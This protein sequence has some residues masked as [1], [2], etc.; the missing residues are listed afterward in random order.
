MKK[1]NLLLFLL[2]SIGLLFQCKPKRKE[3][4]ATVKEA[5]AA[6]AELPVLPDSIAN[7]AIR[8][9]P[10]K[11][12]GNLIV[13]EDGKPVQLQGM[14][15][16]WSQWIG[17]YYNAKAIRWLKHDWNC[18][19]VRAAMAVEYDGYLTQPGL[20]QKKVFTVIDAAVKEGLYVIV[21]WHDHHGEDH[22]IEAK[23]FFA[24]VA[25]RYGHLPNVIYETY[26]EPMY[27]S[28]KEILKPYHQAII[29]TIRYYDPDNLIVCGTPSWSQDVQVAAADPL[30]DANVAYTLHFYAGTHRED[31]RGKAYTALN[32]GAALMVT[33]YGLS[34]ASG[35]EGIY[36][37]ETKKWWKFMDDHHLSSC[38]WSVA[39]KVES[40][41]ALK[42]G[43][44]ASGGWTED[45]LTPSGIIVRNHLRNK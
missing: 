28:W 27:V 21:D 24:T 43:A 38:N 12:Q 1:I 16:F 32:N 42:P 14:S 26:N 29:D 8:L 15:L 11:V 13:G 3:A 25:K 18:T 6:T 44:S 2:M 35:D 10:L 17:K 22:L 34:Q 33:E 40:S 41:A 31:L 37:E 39:D 19:I 45:L 20:E 36:E 23:Q 5:A 30:P 9:S 4:A 7:P